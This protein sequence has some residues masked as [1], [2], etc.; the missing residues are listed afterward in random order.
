MN[1]RVVSAKPNPDYTITL[2]FTNGEIRRFDVTPNL[3]K[4]IFRE[5]KDMQLFNSIKPLLGS[6][7]WQ[8]GQDFC[9]D[10]LYVESVPVLPREGKTLA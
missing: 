2:W 6:I 4:G 7:Q 9:P 8:N 1:Q 10:T 3:H 5:L